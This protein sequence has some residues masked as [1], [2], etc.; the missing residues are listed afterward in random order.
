[1]MTS[2]DYLAAVRNLGLR[3]TNVATVFIDSD[4]MTH[5]VPDPDRLPPAVREG[6]IRRLNFAA[7]I[8]NV[9]SPGALAAPPSFLLPP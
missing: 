8:P 4:G 1:M 9:R 5:N 2:E 7:G 6:I 3:P